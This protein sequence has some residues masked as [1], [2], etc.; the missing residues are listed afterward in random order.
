MGILKSI[1]HA[2]LLPTARLLALSS[3]MS[4]TG[5]YETFTPDLQPE[6]V[7]CINSLITA[8]EPI[9]VTV[10]HTWLYTDDYAT[11]DHEVNDA[12]VAIYA[13]EKEVGEEYIPQEGDRV[14]IVAVS[15]VYGCA[16]AEVTV[17][18]AV[19]IR[20][21]E[22]KAEITDCWAH[23][24]INAYDFYF[25]LKAEM[26]LSDPADTENFYLFSYSPFPTRSKLNQ[27]GVKFHTGTFYYQAEPIF[28]EHIGILD[29][30]NGSDAD[31]FTFFTDRSF[32][33]D[34]YTLNL[35]FYN[36]EF[37]MRNT[38]FSDDKLDCGLVFKLHTISDSYY[39]WTAYNWYTSNG[40]I[41]DFEEI[42]GIDL[43]WGYSNVSTHAGV[44]AAQSVATYTLNLKEFLKGEIAKL[45]ETHRDF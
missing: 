24:E 4:L 19:P 37:D 30:I 23:P 18:A 5:C 9:V 25:R 27:R 34:S 45:N 13:N 26:T 28:A 11:L 15:P 33:G 36:M 41:V 8:G 22:W 32:S 35:Q 40:A 2:A 21:L 43:I 1:F 6:N 20:S 31:G 17:P 38:A 12:T 39:N 44:V 7:L 14:R 16:E 10:T 3:G 42:G 29:A